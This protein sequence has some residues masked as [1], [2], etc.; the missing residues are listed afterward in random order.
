MSNES[1]DNGFTLLPETERMDGPYCPTCHL[2]NEMDTDMMID[3][4]YNRIREAVIERRTA[5][6]PGVAFII[7]VMTG[8]T[9]VFIILATNLVPANEPREYHFVNESGAITALSAFYLTAASAFSLA[10]MVV[11]MRVKDPQKWVWFILALGFAFLSLD[12]LL[13]FHERVGRMLQRFTGSGL[14]R[15]WDDI[16]VLLYGVAVLPRLIVVLP[17]LM[18]WRM[19]LEMF[20]TAFVFYGIHTFVD[21][22]TEPPTSASIILEESAKLVCGTFLVTGTFIGFIGV[23]WKNTMFD[24]IRKDA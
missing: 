24:R 17:G 21:S 12:E 2:Q 14:F 20:A 7:V 16:F 8:C 23:L 4:F 22:T 15:S 11:L 3:R 5:P 9:L 1:K 19:V 13:Q 10:S 18:R 6:L